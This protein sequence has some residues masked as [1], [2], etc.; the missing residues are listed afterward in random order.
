MLS[1]GML[2]VGLIAAVPL[3]WLISEI[4]AKDLRTVL[5]IFAIGATT[6]FVSSLVCYFTHMYY[7]Q[8]FGY[9]TKDLIETSLK[10]IEDGHLER[11]VK[12]WR[13]LNEQYDPT[14]ETHYPAY[15]DLVREATARMHGEIPI[16]PH[17]RWDVPALG[18][19]TWVGHWEDDSG[20]SIDIT[21]YGRL[22]ISPFGD[23]PRRMQPVSM[24]D[25]FRVLKFKEEGLYGHWLHAFTLKNKYEAT[26]EWFDLEK[27]AVWR[28]EPMNKFRRATEEEKQ[29]T[30][31]DAH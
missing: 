17:S 16:E 8:D 4:R 29:M 15:S 18:R 5:G 23:P 31:Q 6:F 19:Q 11:V 20:Y 27:K 14:Y 10:Q 2:V 12:V 13:G 30:Q 26:H 7:N 21:D 22:E 1:L 9:A 25:D 28:I 24:S 3:G